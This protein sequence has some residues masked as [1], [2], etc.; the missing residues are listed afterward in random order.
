M[1]A[2]QPTLNPQCHRRADRGPPIDYFGQSCSVDAQLRGGLADLEIQR[3]KNVVPQREAGMWGGV[4]M[5]LIVTSVVILIVHQNGI[6]VFKCESQA[7]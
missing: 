2:S 3:R 1:I 4:N 5:E 6:T 7:L